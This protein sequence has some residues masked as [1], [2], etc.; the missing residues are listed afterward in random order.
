[1][2]K[3]NEYP[4]IRPADFLKGEFRLSLKIKNFCQLMANELYRDIP[5]VCFRGISPPF[6][7]LLLQHMASYSQP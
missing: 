2:V 3:D 5:D 7:R 4:I 6:V 1:M